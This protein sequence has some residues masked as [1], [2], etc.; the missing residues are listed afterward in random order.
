MDLKANLWGQL[1]L[2][3]KCQ[4][5]LKYLTFLHELSLLKVLKVKIWLF[6]QCLSNSVYPFKETFIF[7]NMTHTAHS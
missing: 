2:S 7:Y 6:Y 4:N 3:K 1:I 5:F